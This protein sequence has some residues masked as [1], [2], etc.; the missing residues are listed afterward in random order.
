MLIVL[1]LIL[2]IAVTA[3]HSNHHRP[4]NGRHEDDSIA[5]EDLYEP[6][7]NKL[8]VHIVHHTHNDVG[9]LRTKE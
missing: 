3:K 7:K 5:L 6:F 4:I 8:K 2:S 9:W 1:F